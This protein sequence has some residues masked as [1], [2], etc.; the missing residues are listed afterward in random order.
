LPQ[1]GAVAS[2]QVEA[3]TRVN[4]NLARLAGAHTVHDL[5]GGELPDHRPFSVEQGNL[6][7]PPTDDDLPPTIPIHVAS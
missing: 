6:L 7:V 2:Q 5:V 1:R 3:A 4:Q